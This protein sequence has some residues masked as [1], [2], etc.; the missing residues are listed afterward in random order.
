[1]LPLQLNMK[2]II[3]ND[4]HTPLYNKIHCIGRGTYGTVYLT[5][6]LKTKQKYI[7]KQLPKRPDN[8][9]VPHTTLREISILK[10]MNNKYI[11]QMEEAFFSPDTIN[12]VFEQCA[13]DLQQYITTKTITI[14]TIKEFSYQLLSGI[15][16]LHSKAI[17][18]RD[19]KPQNIL[20]TDISQPQVKLCD[21]GLSREVPIPI[22][23]ITPT[24]I[25]TMWYKP[26]ELLLG[27]KITTKL[28]IW[29]LGCVITEMGRNGRAL[30]TGLSEWEM[31]MKI[32]QFLGTPPS[33]APWLNNLPHFSR[34][35]PKFK[36]Q[37]F[38]NSMGKLKFNTYACN[39]LKVM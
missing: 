16:Y 31:L 22:S 15:T 12:I 2:N 20:I 24:N 7:I 8:Q 11:I 6:N 10:N 5:E 26:P 34:H 29:S 39:L 4:E 18:H 25:V 27:G 33:N 23:G 32:I 36:K 38:K 1:M 13:M 3:C 30:F 17:L 21:F 28:D 37:K 14:Q 9:G 19:I 35:L